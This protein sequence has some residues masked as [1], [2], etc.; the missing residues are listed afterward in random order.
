L[1]EYGEFLEIIRKDGGG[2]VDVTALR[3]NNGDNR[4]VFAAEMRNF[5][6]DTIEVLKNGQYIR[7]RITEN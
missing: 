5:F 7:V 1:I 4:Q 6:Q 2:V 3:F